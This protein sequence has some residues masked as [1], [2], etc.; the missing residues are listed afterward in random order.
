M[1][2]LPSY[3]YLCDECDRTVIV[4]PTNTNRMIHVECM[5]KDTG[6]TK[7]TPQGIRTPVYQ[8]APRRMRQI[9]LWTYNSETGHSI[10]V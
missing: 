2:L 5:G 1:V 7:S 6:K 10:G 3:V 8:H 4:T 9:G